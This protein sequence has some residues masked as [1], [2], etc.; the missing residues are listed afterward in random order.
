[1]TYPVLADLKSWLKITGDT[2]DD[3]LGVI[4]ASAVQWAESHTDRVF[5]A[6][7]ETLNI[8]LVR[9]FYLTAQSMYL[10]RDLVSVDTLTNGDGTE[11]SSDDFGLEPFSGPP[12][13]RIYLLNGV[14]WRKDDSGR[15]T[16]T[17]A[18]DWGYSAACPDDV[19]VAILR[20]AQVNY[21]ARRSGGMGAITTATRAGL[22][23]APGKIPDDAAATLERYRRL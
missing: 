10:G 11:V 2:E 21:L 16:V 13:H 17:I 20:I 7:T 19:F 22:M 8:P 1:M 6:E 4:L 9:P 5:V 12:Y 23:M 14:Y 15:S 3:T 18:G